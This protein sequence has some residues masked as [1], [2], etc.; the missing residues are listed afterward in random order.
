MRSGLFVFLGGLGAL[1][2]DKSFLFI[3]QSRRAKKQ[4]LSIKNY[5]LRIDRQ[6]CGQTPIAM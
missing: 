3:P 6:R 1:A 4:Q 5:E 2:G